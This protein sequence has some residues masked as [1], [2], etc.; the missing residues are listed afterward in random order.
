[1]KKL[2]SIVLLVLS[3]FRTGNPCLINK[4]PLCRDCKF[5]IPSGVP[6]CRKFGNVDLVTG[7]KTYDYAR[8]ARNAA[9]KCGE[10][11]TNFEKNNFKLIT[12]PYYFIANNF[13]S[14]SYFALGIISILTVS[15]IKK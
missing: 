15:L 4:Y 1:M 11:A 10:T 12:R 14:L 8:V 7:E 9:D 6:Y 2:K 3:T 13:W 5:F